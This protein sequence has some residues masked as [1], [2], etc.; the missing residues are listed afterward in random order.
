MI[1]KEWHSAGSG[2]GLAGFKK[3]AQCRCLPDHA[4]KVL[5]G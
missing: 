3:Q 2:Y 1:V 5:E 4:L